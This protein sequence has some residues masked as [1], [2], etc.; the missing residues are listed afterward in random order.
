MNVKGSNPKP[1]PRIRFKIDEKS[2]T[3]FLPLLQHRFMMKVDV[4]CSVRDLLVA[5]FEISPEYVEDRIKTIFLDSKPVDDIDAAIVENGSALALSAA[6]PG[7]VGATFRKQGVFSIFRSG[8]SYHTTNN[9]STLYPGILTLKLFNAIL[10]EL[11]PSFLK[12]G[13]FVFQKDFDAFWEKLTPPQQIDLE[14][15]RVIEQTHNCHLWFE[16]NWL[17]NR[18][19]VYLRTDEQ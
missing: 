4:G 17:R 10:T 14:N 12:K 11:G 13:V 7:L 2:I 6:M 3:Y 9:K 5:Q 19:I 15:R 16:T 18:D 1:Y 8:I